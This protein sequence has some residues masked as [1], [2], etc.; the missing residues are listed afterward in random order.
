MMHRLLMIVFC[1]ATIVTP[2]V[3]FAASVPTVGSVAPEFTLN[4]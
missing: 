2:S 4:S 3:V 1:I